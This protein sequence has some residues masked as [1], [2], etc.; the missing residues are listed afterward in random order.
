M[1]FKGKTVTGTSLLMVL[2]VICF[3]TT[4]VAAAALMGTVSWTNSVSDGATVTKIAPSTLGTALPEGA[5]VKNVPYEFG[6]HVVGSATGTGTLYISIAKS[7][8]VSSDVKL[9]ITTDA[10]STWTPIVADTGTTGILT[11]TVSASVD[12]TA[13]TTFSMQVTYL[14]A[15]SYNVQAYVMK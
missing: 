7:G 2:G 12:L 9:N 13:T 3:A 11:Y 8:I 1:K 6:V 5:T 15:G 14:T 10:G 4:L